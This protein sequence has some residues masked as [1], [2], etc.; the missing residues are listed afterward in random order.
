MKSCLALSSAQVLLPL[1]VSQDRPSPLSTS[2]EHFVKL[3]GPRLTTPGSTRGFSLGPSRSI[4]LRALSSFQVSCF[5][6]ISSENEKLIPGDIYFL[7]ASL[8]EAKSEQ[9]L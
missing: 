8:S 5:L 3:L 9:M 4:C 7:R 1:G 6:S 2:L